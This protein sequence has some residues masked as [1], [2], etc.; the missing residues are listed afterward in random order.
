VEDL[1]RRATAFL[2][3][4]A[5]GDP[6]ESPV[7]RR[8]IEA[9]V[10]TIYFGYPTPRRANLLGVDF[11]LLHDACWTALDVDYTSMVDLGA[12]IRNRLAAG[13]RIHVRSQ[14]GTDLRFE[15][16]GQEI[17]VDDGVISDWEVEH[18]RCWNHLPAG[19]VLVAPVRG[20]AEG[21]L[22]SAY[23]DLLGITIRGIRLTFRSGAVVSATADENEDLLHRVLAIGTGDR[24]L[25]GSFSIGINPGILQP[26][27]YAAWDDKVFANAVL[28]L[29]ENRVIGGRNES[30]F[31]WGLSVLDPRITLDDRE[32]VAGRRFPWTSTG[33]DTS[34]T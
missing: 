26:V 2:H 29:G 4:G 21:T 16:G 19:K 17:Y 22:Y 12:S 25:L 7:G 30:N 27:G 33:E 5:P 11:Q 8:L 3:A 31:A 20:T 13:R 9:G 10:R 32:L 1:A 24:N 14:G 6:L 34:G 15:I 18:R 28:G 23:A